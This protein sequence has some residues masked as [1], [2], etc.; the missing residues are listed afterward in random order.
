MIRLYN[1]NC[2]N[3]LH[4]QD[5]LATIKDRKCIVVTD[6]PFNVDYHY[7][8]YKDSLD[9]NDYLSMLS[10]VVNFTDLYGYVII[11][12]P[13]MLHKLSVKLS[14][15]PARVVSWV[16]NSNTPR[17]HRDIAFYRVKPDMSQVRQSYKNMNDKR[18]RQRM[19]DG[20]IGG[21]LYDWWEI[22]QVKNVSKNKHKLSHPC[23]MP[24]EVMK[25]II[26]V[27]PKDCV[28]IDPFMGSGTTGVACKMY[29]VDFIGIELNEQYFNEAQRRLEE[30]ET[31]C[32]EKLLW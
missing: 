4:Q 18:I 32:E 25:N 19:L 27:L 31:G 9:E 2:L 29:N 26:G 13:E 12:Y 15:C 16:Y 1:D 30:I 6:P 3:I 17:Q 14:E 7:N 24:V 10:E 28:I 8:E 22:N 23:I 21:K 5:F 11:H 20:D